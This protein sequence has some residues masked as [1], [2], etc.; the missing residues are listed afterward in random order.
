MATK[1]RIMWL[2]EGDNNSK[3]FHA[4]TKQ[5]RARN[6]IVR[7][8]NESDVWVDEEH[9]I[10]QVAMKYFRDMFTSIA[11]SEIEE[12][13]SEVPSLVTDQMNGMLT[14]LATEDEVRKALFMM[15]QEKF[16]GPD[17]MTSLFFSKSLA[18][19]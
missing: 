6:W 10:E 16:P 4:Q 17:E 1:S 14:A 8:Y 15:H 7:L 12:V 19:N 2:K 13:L 3:K 11:P 5:R 9:E 18:Y